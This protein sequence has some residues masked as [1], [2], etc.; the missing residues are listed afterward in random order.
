MCK[1][2]GIDKRLFDKIMFS[3]EAVFRISSGAQSA[4]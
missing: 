3:D 2:L 4:Q 1:G